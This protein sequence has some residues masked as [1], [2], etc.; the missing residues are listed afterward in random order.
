VI[1]RAEIAALWE[2][3]SELPPLQREALLLREVRGLSYDQ[4]SD[5]LALSR[6]SVRSLLSR[7]RRRIRVRLQD[8]F[9]AV[10][11]A[12]WLEPVL[13]LFGGGSGNAVST[14]TK[15][16]VVG[17]GAA[18]LAGGAA[19]GPERSIRYTTDDQPQ[20]S[21]VPTPTRVR[22]HPVIA[23]APAPTVVRVA[24]PLPTRPRSSSHREHMRDLVDRVV[25]APTQ[26]EP[27]GTIAVVEAPDAGVDRGGGTDV[28]ITD[29]SDTS[30]G[31]TTT[32]GDSS[33]SASSSAPSDG[34]PTSTSGE[35]TG[36]LLVVT[37]SGDGTSSEH[38]GD[39]SSSTSGSDL[40]SGSDSSDGH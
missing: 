34:S 40:T 36:G 12:S 16:A 28:A 3:I 8:G 15:A 24:R 27:V 13:R 7:A 29:T 20:R 37:T 19:V 31:L 6:S 4:L 35:G 38:S 25:T 39:D 22:P 23:K 14:A 21:G 17:L 1:R 30:G 26:T 11:G 10:G 32:S 9:A 2:A 18:A 5:N 33:G